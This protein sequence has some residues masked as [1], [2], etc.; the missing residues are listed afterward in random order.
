MCD[1]RKKKEMSRKETCLRTPLSLPLNTCTTFHKD[2][3]F[4]F[5]Y[6]LQSMNK[7]II[8]TCGFFF[9]FFLLLAHTRIETRIE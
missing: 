5:V 9:L 4:Y 6:H 2:S 1:T 3:I 8:F 7:Y